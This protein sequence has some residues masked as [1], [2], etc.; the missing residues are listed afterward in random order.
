MQT[1]PHKMKE[2]LNM[3]TITLKRPESVEL[4]TVTRD[5]ESLV[6]HLDNQMRPV[7]AVNEFLRFHYSKND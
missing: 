4:H 5:G 2:M 7:K 1:K 6:I 3:S